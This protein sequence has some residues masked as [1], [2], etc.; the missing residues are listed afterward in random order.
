MLKGWPALHLLI[1]ALM[2]NIRS[3]MFTASN[4]QI[5]QSD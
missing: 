3:M 2:E 4:D 5:L 1:F